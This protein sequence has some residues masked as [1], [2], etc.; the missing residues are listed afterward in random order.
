MPE[1]REKKIM[2]WQMNPPAG[3]NFSKLPATVF[4]QNY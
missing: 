2:K 1:N 4:K 3:N